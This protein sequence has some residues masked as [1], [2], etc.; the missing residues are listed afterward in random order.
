MRSLPRLKASPAPSNQLTAIC[1]YSNLRTSKVRPHPL[2]NLSNPL[3]QHTKQT[4]VS[5]GLPSSTAR[6]HSAKAKSAF[7]TSN[8]RQ[9]TRSRKDSD[10]SFS[11]SSRNNNR[12]SSDRTSQPHLQQRFNLGLLLQQHLILVR[13]NPSQLLNPRSINQQTTYSGLRLQPLLLQQ[14]QLLALLKQLRFHRFRQGQ[15]S[16]LNQLRTCRI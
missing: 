16:H 6:I 8:K 4:K 3:S 2:T 13:P 1:T 10:L 11:H 14:P 15:A 9:P 5:T 12:H 7:S